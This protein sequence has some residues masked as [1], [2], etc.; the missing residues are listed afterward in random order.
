MRQG[1]RLEQGYPI[2]PDRFRASCWCGN[3]YVVVTRAEL[4]ACLT[5]PCGRPGCAQPE[6]QAS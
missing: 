5:H 3:G 2:G 4:L 1:Q 6:R